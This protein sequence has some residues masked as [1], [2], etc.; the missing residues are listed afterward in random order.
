M[1]DIT[2]REFNDLKP[3]DQLRVLKKCNMQLINA[4]S[5]RL[6]FRKIK[7]AALSR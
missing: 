6:I 1:K 7:K 3:E 4:D 2:I 5:N